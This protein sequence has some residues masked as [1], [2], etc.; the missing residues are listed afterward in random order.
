M[1]GVGGGA[2]LVV[3]VAGPLSVCVVCG[4]VCMC[5]VVVEDKDK[6]D[7]CRIFIPAACPRGWCF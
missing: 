5:S 1:G 7:A 3:A 2:G 6:W 4:H